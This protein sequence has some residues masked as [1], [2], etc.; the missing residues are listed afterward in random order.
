MNKQKIHEG[1]CDEIHNL[2]IRKNADYGD[3]FAQLRKR[4][5]N[6]VCMRLFDKLNRLETLIQPGYKQRVS[7]EKI[8]D[9]LMDIANYA[10]MEITERRSEEDHCIEGENI[11]GDC[12]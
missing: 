5:P 6:F 3:S 11:N 8:E 4:Y 12:V 1:L 2:Y 10:I 9:T 7:D